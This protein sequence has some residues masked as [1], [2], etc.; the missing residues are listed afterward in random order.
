MS[1]WW[2]C[3]LFETEAVCRF[4]PQLERQSTWECNLRLA[5]VP[6]SHCSPSPAAVSCEGASMCD[7]DETCPTVDGVSLG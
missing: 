1:R 4:L 5:C 7:C 3:G 2:G 6:I